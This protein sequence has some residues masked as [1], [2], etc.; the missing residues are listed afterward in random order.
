MPFRAVLLFL[1]LTLFSTTLSAESILNVNQPIQHTKISNEQLKQSIINAAQ[2][3]QWV[4]TP[5]DEN[6]LSATYKKSNYMAK[7]NI[8]YATTFYAINYV[9][10]TRMRHKGNTIHPTYNK[11]IRALQANI[12]SNI[13]RANYAQVA[14]PAK[15]PQEKEATPQEETIRSKLINLKQLF[16]DGLITQEEYASKRK[17]LL[18][19]Y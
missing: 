12:V 1:T 18:D 13:K 17:S 3:Q 14:I 6:T 8:T 10:S 9:D 19:S 5:I 11:L 7:I 2:A 15:Q 16:D 4:I